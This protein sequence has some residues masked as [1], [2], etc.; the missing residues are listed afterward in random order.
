MKPTAMADDAD[1]EQHRHRRPHAEVQQRHA[2]AGRP[3][4]TA[5]RCRFAPA[6]MTKT[7][8]KM[9]HASS[10]RNSTATRMAAFMLGSVTRQSRCQAVAPSIFAASC[11]SLGHLHEAG[12]QEQRDERRRLPDLREDDHDQR[13][14]ARA[15][16]AEARRARASR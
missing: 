5:S 1:E 16:P 7:V 10:V 14:P 13:R 3:G 2:S 4:T 8:S 15:E 11:S 9:R 12:Q 6:V